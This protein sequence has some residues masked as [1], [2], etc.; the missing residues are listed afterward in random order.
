MSSGHHNCECAY[1]KATKKGRSGEAF[2]LEKR[3]IEEY[4]GCGGHENIVMLISNKQKELS[5]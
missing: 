2:Q 4:V 3:M 5:V 1:C